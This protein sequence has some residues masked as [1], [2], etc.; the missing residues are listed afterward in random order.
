M[1]QWI[2]IALAGAAGLVIGTVAGVI[3][4]KI[5]CEKKI[6]GAE[7]EAKRI[8]AE[9]DKEA[10]T[11]KKEA[12]LGAKEEI[13]RQRNEAEK[14]LK[15]RRSD[16]SRMERRITQKEENLDRKTEALEKKNELLEKRISENEALR[17]QINELLKKNLRFLNGWELLRRRQRRTDKRNRVAGQA[18]TCGKTFKP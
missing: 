15:E 5:I 14:E 8:I 3:I 18:R 10:E 16:I 12:L 2:F 11:I 9:A 4:R 17:E 7:N 6:G 13:L 1:E